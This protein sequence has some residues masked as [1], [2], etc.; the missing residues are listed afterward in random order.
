MQL[1][2]SQGRINTVVY[3]PNRPLDLD[4]LLAQQGIQRQF[5]VMVPGFAGLP[6]FLRGT[7]LLA[8]APGMLRTSTLRDLQHAA[9]PLPCPSL[10]MYMV[11]HARHQHDPAHVWM[12]TQL[13]AVVAQ[14]NIP[15]LATQ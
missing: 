4:R 14:L 3:E 9:V 15:A 12:R 10:P 13:D 5:A 7:D 1:E 2:I 8:T 11:W 6:A